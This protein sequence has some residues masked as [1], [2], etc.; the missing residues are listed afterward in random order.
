MQWWALQFLTNASADSPDRAIFVTAGQRQVRAETGRELV[1]YYFFRGRGESHERAA[2]LIAP[3]AKAADRIRDHQRPFT[4]HRFADALLTDLR[5]DVTRLTGAYAAGGWPAVGAFVTKG[6]RGS[7][8]FLRF[9]GG[10]Y[11]SISERSFGP[12]PPRWV[13]MAERDQVPAVQFPSPST[14][15]KARAGGATLDVRQRRV[16]ATDAMHGSFSRPFP[17]GELIYH[18]HLDPSGVHV[19]VDAPAPPPPA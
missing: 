19:L 10:G 6:S 14:P 8:H 1:E 5:T 15:R 9:S 16:E 3:G 11:V 17:A 7:L 2:R 13:A 4:A 18:L 12:P